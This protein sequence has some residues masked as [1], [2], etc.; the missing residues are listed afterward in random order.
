MSWKMSWIHSLL[1]SFLIGAVSCNMRPQFA[2]NM[3][4]A[5]VPED[6]L[7]GEPIFWIFAT[8]PDN[9]KLIYGIGGRDSY[10]FKV[11]PDTGEVHLAISLDYESKPSLE[12]DII[13]QD[14]E[15]IPFRQLMTII[16]KDCNDN[17]PVFLNT[18]YFAQLLENN[19]V[20]SIVYTVVAEDYDNDRLVTPTYSIDEVI[21]ND[22]QHLFY[23]LANGSIVLNGSLN[24][25]N[26][27][28]FYR[29]LVNAT[30]R[31]GPLRDEIIYRSS[32]TYVSLDI[33]DLPDMDPQFIN[34]PYTVSILENTAINKHILTVSAVDGDKGINDEILFFITHSSEPGLFNLST[35]GEIYVSGPIDREAL[36]EKDEQVVLEVMAQERELNIK[37]E[38]ATS[39]TTVTIRIID[40][41]DNKPQFY[42]CEIDSCDFTSALSDHFTGMLDEHSAVRVPVANLTIAAND[43]DK[44]QHGTFHLYLRGVDANY[45]SVSPARLINSG[46]VQILVRNPEAIDYEKIHLMEVEIVAND[47][48]NL[49]NCCS[50]ASVRINILDINDHI[51][52]FAKATYELEVQE[53]CADGTTIATITATDFDSGSLGHITYQLLPE[54]IRENFYVDPTSGLI[55]VVNGTLLDRERRSVYYATLQAQDGGDAKG[56][57]LLE[58]TILDINDETPTAAGIYNIFTNENSNDISIQIEAYD[59][60]EPNTNNS[61]IEFLLIPSDLS[62][63]F[64]INVTTGL[65][66]SLFPLDR[67]AINE[68]QNG[69]IV[70]TVKLYDLGEPSLSSN[71]N[72]TINVED[73]N[74][75]EPLFRKPE[76][77]F[78]VNESTNGAFV[79][80]LQVEDHD[81]TDLN[82][83][84]S[85]RISQG[86]SGN[87]IIRAQ[88]EGKG[89]FTGD[90]SI[91]P[92]V[93]LDYE[94]QKSFTLIIEAQ[95]N[96]A[97]GVSY[98][99]TATA[100]VQVLDLNDE[101]PYIDQSSLKDLNV[102]ENRTVGIERLAS[103]NATDPDTDHKLEFQ[104]LSVQ[105]LKN[106]VDVG[107][108]CHDWLWLAPTGELYVNRSEDVDYE[109]C[110]LVVILLRVEDKM[111]L[112]GE[113]YSANVT[114]RVVIQDV[115]D[116]IPEFLE[117]DETFVVVPEAAPFDYQVALVKARDKDMGVNAEIIF[118][119]ASVIFIFSSGGTTSLSNIFNIVPSLEKDYYQGSIRVA[120]SLDVNLKGQYQ[121]TVN[122]MDRG[123][124]PL[125]ATRSINIF[126]VDT[127]YR[128]S[129]TFSKSSDYVREN[130]EEIQKWLAVA[131]G[132]TVYISDIKEA[133]SKS[134]SSRA[135]PETI[136]YVYFVY[137]N[138]TAITPEAL[139][140]IIRGNSVALSE[141][142]QLGLKVIGSPNDPGDNKEN[143]MLYGVIAGLTGAL[144]L[145]L[146]IM[147]TALVCIRKSNKR[148]LRAIKASKIAKA[149]PGEVVQGAE[150]IPGTNKF[151]SDRA[152]PILNVDLGPIVDLGFDETTSVS[153]SVS[154]DSLYKHIL[155][156]DHNNSSTLQEN[157][158]M[159]A[160][161]EASNDERDEPL[162]IALNDRVK[163]SYS[164]AA[165]DTTDL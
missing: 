81:Q 26:R 15:Q 118:S 30:D 150:V 120:T 80:S 24:Y 108:I 99:A 119:I 132:A 20:G 70:L 22:F 125:N 116:H 57:T 68:T 48:G 94:Q 163:N 67:E 74:D 53:N 97:Q 66:T 164:N 25:N 21:P 92:E 152:N 105:C 102:L 114:Q 101:P 138:G 87:F 39:T 140:R 51:P 5:T 162:A 2:A 73:L 157:R 106:G 62:D 61:K 121:V 58:I 153:D 16:V 142:L 59:T 12:I 43:P 33:V 76:F 128:V 112:L 124:P 83:R 110:D 7:V 137:S 60:D 10:Y 11:N 91:D 89:V 136:L 82:N 111:T 141:L 35:T 155:D 123:D 79:G 134:I 8:D 159:G 117:I 133:S 90:L 115:N 98:T 154:V 103:L 78:S 9:D 131:T 41:N 84:V 3:T 147:V 44:G 165:L 86:G 160:E 38:N 139:D 27:S 4:V 47:T 151:N 143:E 126:A 19:T 146:I 71:V 113:R 145:V 158:E 77:H 28:T 107:S 65:I 85:F 144:V 109:L 95:D 88:S 149:L 42:N 50:V 37:N 6:R 14:K 18:P 161:T 122:A 69:R 40:I 100:I 56:T 17:D 29:L 46:Q 55:S 72:V 31:G 127:S 104:E 23:I 49:E 135:D 52:T 156:K 130:S 36:V 32:I 93:K 64:T 45:F 1:I 148:K 34:A 54:S 96:G 13:V 63:N 75:N 129:L